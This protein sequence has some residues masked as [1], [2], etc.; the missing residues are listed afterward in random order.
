MTHRGAFQPPTF[1]DSV[2]PQGCREGLKTTK[3][4]S[5]LVGKPREA[6]SVSSGVGFKT[7]AR[8]SFPWLCFPKPLQPAV[9]CP[10]VQTETA[11]PSP[12]ACSQALSHGWQ[13]SAWEASSSWGR[14]RRL[15][16]CCSDPA[17]PVLPAGGRPRTGEASGEVSEL[18][19]ES[20]RE[21]SLPPTAPRPAA[22]AVQQAERRFQRERKANPLIIQFPKHEIFLHGKRVRS[23]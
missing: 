23:L 9:R 20:A 6:P 5:T 10:L 4:G 3:L 22:A 21:G 16:S 18:E 17:R 15:A 13:P 1:C 8:E 11:L 2:A 19:E 14:T 7:P 12:L